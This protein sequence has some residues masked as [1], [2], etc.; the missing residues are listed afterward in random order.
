MALEL[1]LA[2]AELEADELD[3]AEVELEE[4]L[5]QPAMARPVHAMATRAAT[6][7]LLLGA[8]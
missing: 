7:V 2:L 4:E 1:E 8:K 5:L 3:D 6:G